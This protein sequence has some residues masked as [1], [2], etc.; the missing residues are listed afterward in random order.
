[1]AVLRA[2]AY[3]LR[4]IGTPYTERYVEQVLSNYPAIMAAL[5]AVQFDPDLFTGDPEPAAGRVEP[6]PG[7]SI[8]RALDAVTSLDADRILRTL[9]SGD[10]RD[11]AHQRVPDRRA[12]QPARFR[13]VQARAGEDSLVCPNRFQH[14]RSGCTAIRES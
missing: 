3:Y 9:L 6:D 4:Q 1:M 14:M 11:D 7:A 2:Y 10:Q 12:G 8:T 13:V 5:F